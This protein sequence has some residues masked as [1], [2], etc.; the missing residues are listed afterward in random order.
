MKIL[1]EL[2]SPLPYLTIKF[3]D[4]EPLQKILCIFLSKLHI[5]WL[6]ISLKTVF[7]LFCHSTCRCFRK[8]Y[9]ENISLLILTSLTE[10]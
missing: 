7:L 10:T 2:S 6:N 1:T 5:W 8:K 9:T 3:K 4:K